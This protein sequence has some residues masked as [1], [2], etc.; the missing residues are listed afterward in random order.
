MPRHIALL[1]AVN[2]KPRWLK[3]ERAR[4]ALS[5]AGFTDVESHIQSGNL[6]VGSPLR[7]GTK[8]AAEIERALAAEAG[9]EVPT[10]VRSPREMRALASAVD[11]IPPLLS[12]DGRRYVMFAKEAITPAGAAAFAGWDVDG[13]RLAM[14]D[15]RH[16]LLE[17][18][19][20]AHASRMTNARAERLGGGAFTTRDL[21]VVRT[22]S[23]RWGQP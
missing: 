3:M 14:V 5:E 8:V 1:R 10:M 17:L 7:S 18:T 16:V 22:L 9:F 4:A 11:E 12:A 2:V 13:E 6:L 15:D 23:E 20:S 21:K 19:V